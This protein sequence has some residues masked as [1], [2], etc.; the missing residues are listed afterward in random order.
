M[1]SGYF[2]PVIRLV[3][4]CTRKSTCSIIIS[5]N[6]Q[7]PYISKIMPIIRLVFVNYAH[8]SKKKA[9]IMLLLFTLN[10]AK[11]SQ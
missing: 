10:L 1:Y 3:N 7:R 2:A 8:V 4:F 11:I 6:Y 5:C 9:E